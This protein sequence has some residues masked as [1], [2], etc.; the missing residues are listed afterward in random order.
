V[1]SQA[2][3]TLLGTFGTSVCV[4]EFQGNLFFGNT[5]QAVRRILQKLE[6]RYL[7]LDLGRVASIDTVAASLLRE[8]YEKLAAN[9]RAVR[10]RGGPRGDP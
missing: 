8:L 9:E 10:V 1:R 5:E 3:Q 6:A 7:I 4:F 2:A